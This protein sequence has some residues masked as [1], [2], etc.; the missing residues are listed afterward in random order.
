MPDLSNRRVG[1]IR[2]R[3]F[4]IDGL[5]MVVAP[6]ASRFVFRG[7]GAAHVAAGRAFGIDLPHHALCTVARGTRTALWM[8]PDE[9]LL[10]GIVLEGVLIEAQLTEAL[11]GLA[12]S[13]VDVGHRDVAIELSGAKAAATLN[14][15]CPLDLHPSVFATGLCKRTLLAKA[16][17]VLWRKAPQVFHV[18][19]RRS[20]S[21]YVWQFLEQA[22]GDADT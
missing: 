15:G 22:A 7:K 12:Y 14:V 5:S 4:S 6:D 19:I 13:L 10:L 17:I 21:D 2:N 1:P 3:F 9:W 11:T 20:Y 8:G 18:Q 16:E